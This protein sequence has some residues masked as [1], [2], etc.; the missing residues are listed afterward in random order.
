[1]LR[2]SSGTSVLIVAVAALAPFGIAGAAPPGMLASM[3]RA[4]GQ[5]LRE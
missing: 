2:T 4:G 1:M 5:S 3:H